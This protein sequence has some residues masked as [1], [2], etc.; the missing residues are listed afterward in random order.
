VFFGDNVIQNYRVIP[1]RNWKAQ[2]YFT[3]RR[4]DAKKYQAN[5]AGQ[6]FANEFIVLTV[7]NFA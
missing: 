6:P 1:E 5:R 7:R 4:Y 2:C 3:Q